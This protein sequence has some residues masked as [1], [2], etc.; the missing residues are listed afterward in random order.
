MYIRMFLF[1]YLFMNIDIYIH[2]RKDVF[3]VRTKV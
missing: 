2:L 3:G 1:M